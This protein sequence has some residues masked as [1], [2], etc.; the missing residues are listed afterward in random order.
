MDMVSI[1]VGAGGVVVGVIIGVVALG[2][3]K[4]LEAAKADLA[5]LK[6]KSSAELDALKASE[7][8]LKK[9]L[10]AATSK[11]SASEE[12]VAKT[13]K[14]VSS[15]QTK[16]SETEQAR[17]QAKQEAQSVAADR[18]KAEGR[19]QQ[20]EKL[21]GEATARA[22]QLEGEL[23]QQGDKHAEELAAARAGGGMSLEDAIARFAGAG[24]ALDEILGI[25]CTEQGQESAVLA[26]SNGIVVASAGDKELRDGIAA[27]A[28]LLTKL[29]GQFEGMI[30]FGT[31][32]GFDLRDA[33]SKVLAGR[34]TMLSGEVVAVATFGP[35][36]PDGSALDGAIASLTAAL[37]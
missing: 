27:V 17:D 22:A 32:R 28:Q 14:E 13:K 2:K 29:G 35:H 31:V 5:E 34:A 37:S 18:D 15:L 1:L 36:P 25:L 26:D 10:E 7:G 19:A 21:V 20:A 11:A 23:K 33:E 24:G 4:E 16:L 9:D 6:R 12:T 30:P 8:K 3:G